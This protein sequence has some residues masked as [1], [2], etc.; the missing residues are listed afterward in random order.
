MENKNTVAP[1][2]AKIAQQ[3]L[4]IQTLEARNSDRLDFHELSVWQIKAALEAAYLVG[5][6]T[7]TK[8]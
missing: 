6:N 8:Q 1:A 2:L 4:G 7:S 3:H 5:K